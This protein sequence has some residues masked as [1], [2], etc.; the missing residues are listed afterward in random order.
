[1]I[2]QLVQLVTG[3]ESPFLNHLGFK[4]KKNL[5]IVWYDNKNLVTG[6]V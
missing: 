4:K 1:M 3:T 6:K 2:M 5:S